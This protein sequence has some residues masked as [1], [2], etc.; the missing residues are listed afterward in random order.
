MTLPDSDALKVKT[1]IYGSVNGAIGVIASIPQEHFNFFMK[2]QDKMT[3][4]IKGVGGF[5]HSEFVVSILYQSKYKLIVRSCRWRAFENERKTEPATNFVDGDLIES[6]SDLPKSKQDL[7]A[8]ML[9]TTTE[10]VIKRIEA[11]ASAI[12]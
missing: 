3:Q 6:F 2:L 10:E 5:S 4:V 12:H 11:I 8:E 1:L 9:G 7:I